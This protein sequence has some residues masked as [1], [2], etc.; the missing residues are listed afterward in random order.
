L[1]LL[2]FGAPGIAGAVDSTP[3]SPSGNLPALSKTSTLYGIIRSKKD[4]KLLGNVPIILHNKKTDISI[5]EESNNQGG[6][7]FTD[8]PPG[9]YEILVGGGNFSQSRKEGF[10]KAGMT[11]EIDFAIQILSRGSSTLLGTI[12]QKKG[13]SETPISATIKAKNLVTHEIYTLSSDQDGNYAL[14]QIPGGTYLVQVTKDGFTPASETIDIS[15]KTREN[16]SLRL[17]RTARAEIRA[18]ANKKIHDNTGAISIVDQKKFQQN[19]TTGSGYTLMQNTPGIE[20]YSRSG[21]QGISGGMNYMSCRGYTVGGA[22]TNPNGN[23]GIEM[24]VEGVPMNVEADGG[25]VY[26]LGIMNTDVKSATVNRGVTTSRETGSYAAGCSVNF[27]LVDPT[28]EAFQTI[29]AGGGSYGLYYTSYVNNSGIN[30]TTNIGGY[31]DFTIIHQDGFQQFTP[32]TE[33]Q[34]YGNL[35]KYL[36]GGKLYFIT[37]ANYKS[38][39]RGASMS[40]AN[41]NTYPVFR[42][43]DFKLL[44]SND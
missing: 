17:N 21:A 12:T 24:S 28:Q 35:T 14:A 43:F 29:N 6:Y 37:T 31:N 4:Q 38:Y 3:A 26:D 27:K 32:L 2:A 10:L 22:N 20:Y 42:F 23:A 25:E 15:G 5:K 18:E 41:F 16:I 39:D 9:D 8:L 7:L 44:T 30:S 13:D 33:Y 11:G 40:Q 34:Y 36:T 1:A 19:L